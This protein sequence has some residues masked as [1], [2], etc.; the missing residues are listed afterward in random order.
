MWGKLRVKLV[1]WRKFARVRGR[2]LW[3]RINGRQLTWRAYYETDT[4][5]VVAVGSIWP[6]LTP[7][8]LSFVAFEQEPSKRQVL[9]A[10]GAPGHERNRAAAHAGSHRAAWVETYNRKEI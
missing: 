6:W 3:L 9:R 10:V 5:K 8:G 7:A 2:K 4:R 1:R